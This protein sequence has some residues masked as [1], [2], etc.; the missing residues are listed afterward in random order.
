MA[1]PYL[2]SHDMK[3]FTFLNKKSVSLNKCYRYFIHLNTFL[4]LVASENINMV[5]IKILKACFERS[6]ANWIE[7]DSLLALNF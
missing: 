5:I 4:S 6:K 1:T 2:T 3:S 7:N